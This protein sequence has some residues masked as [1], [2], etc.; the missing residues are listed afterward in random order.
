MIVHSDSDLGVLLTMLLTLAAGIAFLCSVV[1][2]W[3]GKFRSAAKVA[4]ATLAAMVGWVLIVTMI[5]FASPQM[6]VKVG[7]SYCEDIRCIGIDTVHSESNGS[8]TIYKL[9]VHL[10]S[11]ANT[12]KVSFGNVSLNVVDEQGHRFPMIP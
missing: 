11:D 1:M 6:I 8:E 5:S 4:G 7:D 10:F 3:D 12:V 2:V 9:D